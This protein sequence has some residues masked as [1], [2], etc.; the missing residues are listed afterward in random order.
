[1]RLLI[2]GGTSF[3]GRAVA[4]EAVC[5]RHQVTT[6]NRGLTGPD[7]RGVETIRGDR[8]H[9]DGLSELRGRSFDAVIDP[10]G[11]VPAHVL[12]TARALASATSFYAFVSSVSAYRDWKRIPAQENS[13]L[14]DGSPDEDGDPA[15]YSNYG[16]RKAGCE[17][18]VA[19]SFGPA[20]LIVRPG[21]IVGPFDNVGHLPWWLHRMASGGRVVAPGDPRR[22]VQ[23]LDVRD[24]AAFLVALVEVRRAGTFNAI[25]DALVSMG[26]WLETC[27]VA[28]GPKAELVWTDDAILISHDVGQWD[29]LPFWQ[30]DTPDLAA[31]W[32]VPGGAAAAAGLR[33]RSA[34]ETVCDT[35]AWLDTGGQVRPMP[36][37]PPIGLDPRK[38]QRVLLALS[39][40]E[41]WTPGLKE[42]RGL[43]DIAN[44]TQLEM[45]AL[46]EAINVADGH[47]RQEPSPQQRRIVECFTELF[48]G[49]ARATYPD[50]ETRAQT[51]FLTALGQKSAPIGTGRIL[52]CYS[53]SV[54]ME[55]VARALTSSVGSVGLI[56]PTF[57]NIPDILAGV[58]LHLLPLDENELREGDVAT[59]F[60]NRFGCLF[61][62]TPNN[63]TG[64]VMSAQR[65]AA[66]AEM[67]T[68]RNVILTLDTSFRGF[69]RR[70]QYD[71]YE[72]LDGS[73]CRYIVIEDT[74]KL[75]PTLDLKLGFLVFSENVGLPVA[76]V[77]SDLLL[78]VSGFILAVVE[79]FAL[80]ATA[81]GLTNLQADIAHNR[82][83]LRA[84]LAPV[85][86]VSFPDPDNRVSV[87]RIGLE[88]GMDS[89]TVARRLRRQGAHILPCRRFYWAQPD[90]GDPFLRVALARSPKVVEA[91]ARV[92]SSVIREMT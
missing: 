58:G 33:C 42:E 60:E 54:A 89:G 13:P 52:S 85:S 39:R 74:G 46:P 2:I 43:G 59:L 83:L 80:D 53:S 37:L 87:E 82:E 48:D 41:R 40:R 26:D 7:V 86:Q 49:A 64:G 57:D 66:L 12:R 4:E 68:D 34:S 32:Q 75:W 63:P 65:L 14:L 73:G 15:D 9:P 19:E 22:P 44:L 11:L 5:R 45:L 6:F 21:T 55:I 31:V 78:N 61:A 30:A 84:V 16:R 62:T 50:L 72:I 10:G 69:D 56:H 23:I 28:A 18:A 20:S 79:R 3:V 25:P 71:H 76:R 51:A 17:L 77:H 8:S 91:A 1:M 24:L 29:E 27:R 67:C 35:W 36:G 90:V 38:E 81:G 70:A 88:T 92:L 47:A